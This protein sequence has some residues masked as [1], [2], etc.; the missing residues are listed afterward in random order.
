MKLLKTKSIWAT[1]RSQTEQQII[2]PY[3]RN[4]DWFAY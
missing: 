2:S 1:A 4:L 3:H